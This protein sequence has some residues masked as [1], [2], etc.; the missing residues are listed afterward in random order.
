MLRAILSLQ[1]DC[2]EGRGRFTIGRF[3]EMRVTSIA[4]EL[5]QQLQPVS[6]YVPKQR[7]ARRSGRVVPGIGLPP[8]AHLPDFQHKIAHGNP[9]S[10][11]QQIM[12][13]REDGEWLARNAQDMSMSNYSELWQRLLWTEEKQLEVDQQL[14]VGSFYPQ[15]R[16][17]VNNHHREG[18]LGQGQQ[19]D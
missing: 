4:P 1:F 10:N 19:R 7:R 3:M 17:E 11:W 16:L 8:A 15:A 18:D 2:G 6:P 14:D 5:L 12:L 9:P 13:L